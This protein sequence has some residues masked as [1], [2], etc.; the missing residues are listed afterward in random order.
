VDRPGNAARRPRVDNDRI[1]LDLVMTGHLRMRAIDA[2]DVK[3]QQELRCEGRGGAGGRSLISPTS[4][5]KCTA[6]RVVVVSGS[7]LT[8]RNIFRRILPIRSGVNV[9]H[10]EAS[11]RRTSFL[12]QSLPLIFFEASTRVCL[13][14]SSLAHLPSPPTR[15]DEGPPPLPPRRQSP[16]PPDASRVARRSDGA[17]RECVRA[18]AVSQPRPFSCF[19]RY[20]VPI[21]GAV[22]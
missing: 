6:D 18:T 12:G 15:R 3:E 4:S 16:M 11:V 8:S 5:S 13:P 17:L 10:K 7:G 22:Y 21:I 2:C 19:L 14:S 20:Y 9:Q 1:Q